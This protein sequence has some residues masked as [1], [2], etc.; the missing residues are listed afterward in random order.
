MSTEKHQCVNHY[1]ADLCKQLCEAIKEAQVNSTSKAERQRW[2][3]DHKSNAISLEPGD[4]VL[5]KADAYKGRRKVKDWWEK[6]LYEVDCRSAKG[7]PSY[8]MKNQQTRCSWVL[9]HP[10]NGSS[11]MFRCM[12]W[13]DKMCL[14]HPTG[15]Y[16]ESEWEWGSTTK[17]KVSAAGLVSDRWDS[18]RVVN[19]KFCAFLRMFSGASLL[20]QGWKSL[21]YREG[22]MQMS[23]L[24]FWIWRY[25]WS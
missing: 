15:T 11:F 13:A 7:I 18:S 17:C 4:L 22:D 16:S 19:R 14:H 20:D 23:M 5:V 25:W 21:M 1:I 24:A 3:Y 2:Y 8:L 12:S 10:H 6:E 9:H